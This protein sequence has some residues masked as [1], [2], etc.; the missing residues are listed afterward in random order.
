[1]KFTSALATLFASVAVATPTPTVDNVADK[2]HLV[3]RASISDKATLGYATL[4]GG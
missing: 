2:P 4:N 3:K 1:M